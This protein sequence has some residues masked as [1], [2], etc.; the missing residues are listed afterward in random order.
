ML[1]ATIL[2]LR[3]IRRGEE[4]GERQGLIPTEAGEIAPSAPAPA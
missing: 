4:R 3:M 1:G 2:A